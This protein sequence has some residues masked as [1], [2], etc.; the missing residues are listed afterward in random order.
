[1]TVRSSCPEAL[2]TRK[3]L[4]VCAQR[5]AL[6]RKAMPR[7]VEAETGTFCIGSA[8]PSG[9]RTASGASKVPRFCSSLM[10]VEDKQALF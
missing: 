9:Q 1:M 2:G 5:G 6:K 8:D 4:S 10:M 3:A 7:N